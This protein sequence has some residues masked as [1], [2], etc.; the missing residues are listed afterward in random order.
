MILGYEMSTAAKK[1]NGGAVGTRR[2]IRI[3][4]RGT[5][6][7]VAE[8][9]ANLRGPRIRSAPEKKRDVSCW[10]MLSKKVFLTGE[11]NFSTPPA[12]LTRADVGGHIVS[13]EI[14][15]RASYVSC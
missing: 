15:H 12:R 9:P 1:R 7:L 11:L 14:D 5:G 6:A 13:Q 4:A 3:S 8:R 10:P 2:A